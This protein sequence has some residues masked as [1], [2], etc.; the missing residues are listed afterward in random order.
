LNVI[1][2]KIL[3]LAVHL[4]FVCSLREGETAGIEVRTIDFC[5]RSYW[6]TQEVQRVSDKS[7]KELSH[8]EIFRIFLKEVSTA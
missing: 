5:D 7:L 8:N 1:E 6:I 4:A 3:H 2:D